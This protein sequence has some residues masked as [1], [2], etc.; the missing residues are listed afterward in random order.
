MRT[1]ILDNSFATT[2]LPEGSLTRRW[3]GEPVQVVPASRTPL[4]ALDSFDSLILTGSESSILAED[5]WIHRQ[6]DFV[7]EAVEKNKPVLGICFGHQL[8]ARALWGKNHV[9][10]APVPEFGWP[11]LRLDTQDPLFAGLPEQARLFCSHFDEVVDPPAGVAI[12]ADSEICGV[13]A[14]RLADKAVWGV[15]S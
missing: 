11:T 5:E 4:P 10:R 7:N 13:H 12:T 8:I 3:C 14:F 1:L 6:M 15:Q 9:R 2:L